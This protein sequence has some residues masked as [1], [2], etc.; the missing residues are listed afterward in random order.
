MFVKHLDPRA[1]AGKL[2]YLCW[3]VRQWPMRD[4]LCPFCKG[5]NTVLAYRKYVVTAL[6]RCDSCGLMFRMPKGTLEGSASFYESEYSQGFTTSCPTHDE[7]H[8]MKASNFKG[9]EKDYSR[10]ISIL[11]AAGILPGMRIFD[12]GSSWGYGSWQMQNAGYQVC[13]W[14]ISQSRLDYARRNLGCHI[15]SPDQV[16]DPV[17]CLFGA[18]VLEH[19]DEPRSLWDLGQRILKPSGAIVLFVPNGESSNPELI[20]WWGRVHPLLITSQAAEAMATRT[21]FQAKAF[22][23]PYDLMEIVSGEGGQHTMGDELA[24]IA[25]RRT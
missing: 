25:R 21:G 2:K 15:V 16:K 12:F 22:S 7:L 13:S 1:T 11:K 18:H 19:L 9:T 8:T 3:A 4:K 5:D 14:D 6:Y 24:I 20:H 10:Y 17:D 23:S